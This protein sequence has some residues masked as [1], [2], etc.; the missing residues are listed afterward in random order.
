MPPKFL[1]E[2]KLGERAV[3][4]RLLLPAFS[5]PSPMLSEVVVRALRKV[6]EG[7]SHPHQ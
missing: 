7:R 3:C 2:D 5:V 4:A 1:N 6:R